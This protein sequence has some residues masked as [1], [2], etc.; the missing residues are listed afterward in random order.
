MRGE[1]PDASVMALLI[2]T[3]ARAREAG[4]RRALFAEL[5]VPPQARYRFLEV[6]SPGPGDVRLAYGTVRSDGRVLLDDVRPAQEREGLSWPRPY[7]VALYGVAAAYAPA[8]AA[9]LA[10]AGVRLA[11]PLPVMEIR[12]LGAVVLLVLLRVTARH[13]RSP[14]YAE[15]RLRADG[16]WEDHLRGLESPHDQ[17]ERRRAESG[18]AHARGAEEQFAPRGPGV[19]PLPDF[20]A[21]VGRVFRELRRRRERITEANV[22]ALYGL[23]KSAFHA[24]LTNHYELT[25][26]ELRARFT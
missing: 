1:A 14:V 20:L 24:R 26:P 18:F 12:P 2:D 13:D 19:E 5:G 4:D 25:W 17:R 22:A 10:G 9:A 7:R 8:M 21:A 3:A 15:R 16:T 11:A 23:G 6:W